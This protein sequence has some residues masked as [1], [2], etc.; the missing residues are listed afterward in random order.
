MYKSKELESV[1]IEILNEGKKNQIYACIYRHP[2]MDLDI[3][4][5]QYLSKI[6]NILDKEKK[7]CYLMGDF[8]V[9]LLKA[10]NDEKIS[11]YYEICVKSFVKSFFF[12][13]TAHPAPRN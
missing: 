11:K 2:C 3:F 9:D 8:N 6:M 4:N 1:F 13:S 12:A 7:L 5:E 10:E